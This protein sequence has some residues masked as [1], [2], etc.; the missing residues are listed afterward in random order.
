MSVYIRENEWFS[1]ATAYLSQFVLPERWERMQ[2]VSRERTRYITVVLEDIHYAQNSSA[3]VR[4]CDCFGI[5]DLYFMF[6]NPPEGQKKI[7]KHV[8]Q[9]AEKWVDIHRY[10]IAGNTGTEKTSA[11]VLEH[12][13]AQNYRIV[14]TVPDTGATPLADFNLHQGKIALVMGNEQRG[15]TS[16]VRQMADEFLT[17]PMY[18]FSESF[19]LSVSTAVILS[20]LVAR[21]KHSGIPWQLSDKDTDKLRHSW[22]MKTIPKAK[23]ILAAYEQ[24]VRTL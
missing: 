12:L 4:S 24:S 15:I 13:K 10:L 20:A 19:N 3:V 8:A 1:T 14:A 21:L 17:I 5:Q 9:G 2:E 7:R 6:N 18:G 22:L 23:D 16:T 11:R